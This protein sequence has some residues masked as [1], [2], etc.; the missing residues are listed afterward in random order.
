MMP[1]ACLP[2][3]NLLAYFWM[4]THRTLLTVLP[5]V[6]YFY[7]WGIYSHTFEC[8]LTGHS[9]QYFPEY[10]MP[11]ISQ[12]LQIPHTHLPLPEHS[13][14]VPGWKHEYL[15]IAH[16]Q[17]SPDQPE[18]HMHFPHTHVPWSTPEHSSP[19]FRRHVKLSHSQYLPEYLCNTNNNL[20]WHTLKLHCY[21]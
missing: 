8:W 20:G 19:L 4:V 5:T 14:L 18:W 13:L 10:M 2:I 17:A 9:W 21:L 3:R 6:A 11:S 15:L 1:S 16:S 12:H 7:L